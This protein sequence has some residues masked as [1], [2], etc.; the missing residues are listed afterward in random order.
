MSSYHN[1]ILFLM[2]RSCCIELYIVSPHHI[3]NISNLYSDSASDLIWLILFRFLSRHEKL[4]ICCSIPSIHVSDHLSW[5]P[6][7]LKILEYLSH[8][9]R[10]QLNLESLQIPMDSGLGTVLIGFLQEVCLHMILLILNWN[11]LVLT[12]LY[13]VH[14]Y[15]VCPITNL[16]IITIDHVLLM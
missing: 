12:W 3:L 13:V 7:T 1:A 16:Y 9:I 6:I 10:K 8:N 14:I 2:F 11:V 15:R 5:S 4:D